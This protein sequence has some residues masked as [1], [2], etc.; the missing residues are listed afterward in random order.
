MTG[1][2]RVGWPVTPNTASRKSG[3]SGF[4][5]PMQQAKPGAAAATAETTAPALASMLSLQELGGEAVADREARRHGQD[6][7][8]A[9]ADLQR[10]LLSAGTDGIALQRLA[11]LVASAP[12]GAVDRRLGAVLSAILV[13]AR[14]ELARRG[15]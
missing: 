11:D 8:A 4:S 6:M 7:L 14:V 13:R 15:L 12:H 2:E 3:K 5:V 10:L 9:L 1:V